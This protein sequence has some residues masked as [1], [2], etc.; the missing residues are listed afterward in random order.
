MSSASLHFSSFRT[1]CRSYL[2]LQRDSCSKIAFL[3]SWPCTYDA[4]YPLWNSQYFV[5]VIPC[6]LVKVFILGRESRFFRAGVTLL[7]LRYSPV[8]PCLIQMYSREQVEGWVVIKVREGVG[9]GGGLLRPEIALNESLS[10]VPVF[11]HMSLS[12]AGHVPASS[13]WGKVE[14]GEYEGVKGF[15]F[16]TDFQGI[17][18]II[19]VK[20]CCEPVSSWIVKE[21][22]CDHLPEFLSPHSLSLLNVRHS[23]PRRQPY[24]DASLVAPSYPLSRGNLDAAIITCICYFVSFPP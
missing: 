14:M 16:L 9:W 23:F 13:R 5:R 18:K 7:V 21:L 17:R 8:A 4:L 1:L 6:L 12:V 3:H 2:V 20:V 19:F 22:P 24:D 15:S 10:R 11:H